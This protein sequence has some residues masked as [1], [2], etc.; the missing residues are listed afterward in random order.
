[1]ALPLSVTIIT[2]NAAASLRR[3]LESAAWADE[4]LIVDS[5]SSDATLAIAEEF[6]C[7]ILHNAWPGYGAQKHFAAMQARHDW[8]LSL[9]ADEWLS[10]QLADNV[11]RLLQTTPPYSAYYLTRCNRFMGKWL[12]HG[13]G[14]PDPVLRLFD[15]RR[16]QW[17]GD[18]IHEKVI[19]AGNAG[20]LTGDLFHQSEHGI[21]AYL[22]KQN[23]YTTLQAEQLHKEGKHAGLAQ[24][25]LS[26]ILRFIKFYFLRRGFL[27]GLPG[28]VHI[29]IGCFNSF[30]KYAK[31]RDIE[32]ASRRKVRSADER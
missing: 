5:G 14:Y 16:A 7:R 31:L 9:D 1:M 17:S 8:I 15:R 24:L 32:L 30:M 26:P 3:C 27:D 18:T 13:E 23:R 21:G 10:P 11:R 29:T 12:R 6:N 28:L 2:L 22:E 25:L 4:L 20:R 19:Y